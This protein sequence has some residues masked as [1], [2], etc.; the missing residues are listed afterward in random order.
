MEDP[1]QRVQDFINQLHEA[2]DVPEMGHVPDNPHQSIVYEPSQ[3]VPVHQPAV[4]QTLPLQLL[5]FSPAVHTTRPEVT[6]PK[7]PD[8]PVIHEQNRSAPAPLPSVQP[9]RQSTL[10]TSLPTGNDNH[11]DTHPTAEI[12]RFLLRKDLL[13]SRLTNFNDRAESYHVWKASF[14]CVVNE[15]Q[16]SDSEQLDLLVKWLGVESSKHAVSIRASNADNPKRGLERLW[17]RLDE[18]YGSPEM[19]EASL[20]KQTGKFSETHQQRQ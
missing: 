11:G 16:V 4:Q 2:A 20:K 12:T 17:Q 19:A 3:P 5:A 6:I 1:L 9:T 10:P 7:I 18:R 8:I 15:L 14:K 13:F